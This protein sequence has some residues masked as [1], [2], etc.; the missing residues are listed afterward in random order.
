MF[1]YK[2]IICFLIAGLISGF[3]L[4]L[5]SQEKGKGQNKLKKVDEKKG[6]PSLI[7]KSSSDSTQEDKPEQDRVSDEPEEDRLFRK[8]VI[9]QVNEI[10]KKAQQEYPALSKSLSNE[11][12][13]EILKSLVNTLNRGM[14]YLPADAENIRKVKD[15]SDTA[16]FPTIMI[17]SNQ[18]LYI[19][20]DSLSKKSVQ[21]L[22]EDCESSSNLAKK[23]LGIILDLRTT[24]CYDYKSAVQALGLFASKDNMQKYNLKSSYEQIMKIPIILLT[25]CD[26]EGAA[27][28]FAKLL[29]EMKRSI[30]LGEKTAGIP[31]KKR[32]VTLSNGDFL[33]IPQVP[34]M[35]A[36]MMPESVLPSINFAPYPQL[37]YKKISDVPG[38]E[39]DDM[40][41]QRAVEL[42]I[43]LDALSK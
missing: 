12:K 8:D 42:I 34:D 13:I 3:S 39:K 14:E 7:I 27:E 43:C 23:P 36:D 30:S 2:K 20:L 29:I 40:C 28:V 33:M 32:K 4:V 17:A 6:K 24:Q 9:L 31:F 5:L 11:K 41:I 16:S 1:S 38:A 26:T 22:K 19:R 35:L 18:V 15:K 37:S 21:Q 25:G 10:I